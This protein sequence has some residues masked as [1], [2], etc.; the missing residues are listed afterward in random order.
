MSSVFNTD[1][2]Q[3]IENGNIAISHVRY[4]T[5]GE[6]NRRNVQ[7]IYTQYR[8]G[9]ISIAH[10]GN[11]TNYDELREYYENRGAIFHS[12]ADSEVIA[13]A[14]TE[15]RLKES[16]IEK[17]VYQACLRFKGAY[18]LLVMSPQKLIAVRDPKGYRPLVIGKTD[19]GEI[20]FASESCAL[21]AVGA[22][23]VR[24]IAPGEIV[25]AHNNKMT[26]LQLPEEETSMCVFEFV[27]FS[28]PDSVLEG[29][30][31]HEAHLNAG[32]FLWSEETYKEHFDK[33][34]TVVIGVPDS[35]IDAAIGY[36]KASGLPYEIGFIKN[37]YIG[38]T[39]IEPKQKNRVKNVKLKLNIIK[40]TVRG[41]IV[42]VVDD[43]L[44]RGNTANHFIKLLFEAG[45]KEVHLRL[46]SPMY[47]SPCYYGT[48]VAKG[49]E[50]LANHYNRD[51]TQIASA[52]G[53]TSVGYL[54]ID[55]VVQIAGTDK[56]GFCTEC[57]KKCD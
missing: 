19:C 29:C 26:S 6:T 47:I 46:S 4:S 34:N 43:S 2:L 36:S 49:D 28:R 7:P 8:N 17:A 40:Q 35:G 45:A 10:N 16:T 12:T 31:V 30:S 41:K 5:T 1:K 50:L 42:V 44:V 56:I 48:D 33:E 27:Y 37:K 51:L 55:K 23:L 22:V 14:I 13:Y 24:D 9:Y 53:A 3:K 32:K 38:R 21:D 54:S 18:S 20:I 15:E 11:L 52:I 39:F 57:F 25:T